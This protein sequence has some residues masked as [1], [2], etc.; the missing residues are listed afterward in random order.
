MAAAQAAVGLRNLWGVTDSWRLGDDQHAPAVRPRTGRQRRLRRRFLDAGDYASLNSSVAGTVAAEC[1]G[2]ERMKFSTRLEAR[3]ATSL[4][5]YLHRGRGLQAVAGLDPAAAR[6]RAAGQ[7]PRQRRRRDPL[8][9]Q[10]G[11]A[12]RPVDN[13]RFNFLTRYEHRA[14][15]L[16]GAA[17]S[18]LAGSAGGLNSGFLASGLRQDT[19]ILSAH[20][21][22]QP[23]SKLTLSGRYAFKWTTD[24][25]NG[26]SSK[27]W[28]HL[29]YGRAMWDLARRWDAGVR[30][31][32]AMTGKGGARQNRLRRG[33]RLHG[34]AR[35][36]GVGGLQLQRLSRDRSRRRRAT[37]SGRIPAPADEIRRIAVRGS[38]RMTMQSTLDRCP[39]KPRWLPALMIA[40]ALLL[41][42]MEQAHGQSRTII[43]TGFDKLLNRANLK[44][45]PNGVLM[46]DDARCAIG[47]PTDAWQAG[48]PL[49]RRGIPMDT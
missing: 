18:Y 2:S 21:N 23:V 42:S 27:N 48:N 33:R 24:E 7:E 1:V 35:R 6:R 28:A 26:L 20:A 47:T 37:N 5:S 17:T 38:G 16:S 41:P 43:N 13:D 34:D 39:R 3:R 19:H 32:A 15:R 46:L 12:Y 40:G 9:Q 10:I 36:V 25:S 22:W 31:F 49:I 44:M 29:V 11:A 45:A 8:R 30:A 4:D 14:E